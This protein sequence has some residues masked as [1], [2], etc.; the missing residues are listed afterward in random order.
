MVSMRLAL[1]LLAASCAPVVTLESE[2]CGAIREPISL[3]GD[4]WEDVACA[5][6]TEAAA[7]CGRA[8]VCEY[9]QLDGSFAPTCVV[10]TDCACLDDLDACGVDVERPPHCEL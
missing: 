8:Y 3:P 7:T 5:P 10:A 9:E 1:A 6:E 4:C 2:E